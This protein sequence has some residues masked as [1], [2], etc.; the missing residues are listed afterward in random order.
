M[1]SDGIN[2]KT[3]E[4]DQVWDGTQQF[5]VLS[6]V[7]T[8]LVL[9]PIHFGDHHFYVRDIKGGSRRFSSYEAALSAVGMPVTAAQ[10]DAAVAAM[11]GVLRAKAAA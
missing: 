5:D 7:G 1:A 6:R 10:M 11:Q 9:R 2:S 8:L 3:K 4:G